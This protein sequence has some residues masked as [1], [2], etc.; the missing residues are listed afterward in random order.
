MSTEINHLLAAYI[1]IDRR[2]AIRQN[3]ELAYETAG[4]AM[5]ADVSGFTPLTVALLEE[6][7]P[8]RGAEELTKQLN[9]V[10]DSLINEVYRYRG[11]VLTFAGDAITC[12]FEG[13]DGRAAAACGLAMQ[14]AMK[15]FLS[16]TT[17]AGT[18]ISL[19]VKIAVATGPARRFIVGDPEV[20]LMDA[21]VGDTLDKMA[22]AEKMAERGEVVIAPATAEALADFL[23][24]SEWRGKEEGQRDA[25]VL[26]AV[27]TPRDVEPWPEMSQ[28]VLE[29]TAARPWLLN[30]VYNRLQAVQEAFL[31]EIR[32]ATVMF[33][34]FKGLDFV[35]DAAVNEKVDRYVRWVQEILERYEGTLLQLMFGDK[36][37]VFYAAFGALVA[38]EDNM[39]RA[40]AAARE[41]VNIPDELNFIAGSKIGISQGRVYAG[42]YG[43]QRRRT[44]GVLGSET[45]IAARFMGQAEPGQILVR[46][47][48]AEAVELLFRTKNLGQTYVKGVAKPV[49]M[50]QIMER[51]Q[52]H[53]INPSDIYTTPL[54]GRVAELQTAVHSLDEA[55]QGRGGV[56]DI[57]GQAGSGKS[58]FAAEIINHA[59]DKGMRVAIGYGQTITQETVYAPWRQIFRT[60]LGISEEAGLGEMSRTALARQMAFIQ[61]QLTFLNPQ[62][63]LR[64]PL[65]GDL[66]GLPIPDTP[67]TESLDPKLRKES[68][69]ALVMDMLVMWSAE[70]PLLLMVEDVHLF[71]A[72]SLELLNEIGKRCAEWPLALVAVRRPPVIGADGTTFLMGMEEPP[73]PIADGEAT[74]ITLAELSRDDVYEIIRNRLRGEVR[75]LVVDLV[76]YQAQGNP[77][78]VEELVDLLRE[79]EVI[80]KDDKERWRIAADVVTALE[81]ADCLQE[82]EDGITLKADAALPELTIQLPDSVY[83]SVLTRIDRLPETHKLTLKVASV[84]GRTFELRVVHQVYP[85]HADA[86]YLQKQ[87]TDL[88]KREFVR[89]Y[90]DEEHP[91]AP[92]AETLAEEAADYAF[93]HSITH[94]VTYD[95]LLDQ[96]R[97]QLHR[98]IAEYVAQENPDA[99]PIIAYHAFKGADWVNGLRYHL[100]AGR[101]A[102]KL[103]ANREATSYL[104]RAYHCAQQLKEQETRAEQLEIVTLLGEIL[105]QLGRYEEATNYLN[106][107]LAIAQEL[108]DA[109]GEAQVCRWLARRWELDGQFEQ[110][111]EWIEKGL[112][113]LGG[114]PS[115]AAAEMLIT[116]GL[117]RSRRGENEQ[118]NALAEQALAMGRTLGNSNVLGRAYNLLGHLARLRGDNDEALGHFQDGVILYQQA[119]NLHGT[120]MTHNQMANA[121]FM[122]SRWGEANMQYRS[123]QEMFNRIGDV[124]NRAF[125]ENN[126]GQL[127]L[128]RGQPE[129]ALGLYQGVLSTFKQAGQSLYVLGVIEMNIGAAHVKLG[130]TAEAAQHLATAEDYFRQAA[131]R[132]FLPE[133]YRHIAS[134]HLAAGALG[135]AQAAAQ[136]S[137]VSAR[138][139]NMRHD[140]G[141]ALRVLGQVQLQQGD[142]SAAQATLQQGL[143]LL[144]EAEDNYETAQA[145][146]V[147][148]EVTAALGDQAAADALTAASQAQ[149]QALGL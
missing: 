58:H 77:F 141:I 119:G 69:F 24:Y 39:V 96:Q 125:A 41:L 89:H 108:D 70:Q 6:F 143:E 93:K 3:E 92:E 146:Q 5:F 91:A 68:L 104:E 28:T 52:G 50:F 1:P 71:D 62:W 66:L 37:S 130:Q 13:D 84:I 147:L 11:S 136:Q 118:A 109:E 17:P 105:I 86:S 64:L 30:P 43:G 23:E 8:K 74:T 102:R 78:F 16:I 20:Q 95:T 14:E 72:A 126:L 107:G 31:P 82:T 59:I 10:F 22:D 144:Q 124:Y 142:A 88:V 42:A 106:R 94:E 56:L 65:M 111:L 27:K 60:L 4:A 18:E 44:Y 63:V 40:V 115:E 114:Q 133:L 9:A 135:E 85:G 35:N 67:A 79:V 139:L 7:G 98:S 48:V 55:R 83:A 51:L 34:A 87:T 12:W 38:N 36:G 57:I 121:Y 29:P 45:N 46:P 53:A 90:L 138:E 101:E 61:M 2:M 25:A 148:A 131:V 134:M 127:A 137:L 19:S 73:P 110:A 76:Q 112:A 132:D 122:L 117:I 129:A 128:Y 32:P 26:A 99:A 80:A 149:L 123:A 47:H 140:E 81:K 49:G 116:A 120:A 103:F 54:V 33:V 21:L 97:Q 145:Q 100:I 15:P 75:P 113:R